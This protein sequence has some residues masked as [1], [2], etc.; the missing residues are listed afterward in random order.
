MK[1]RSM[2]QKFTVRVPDGF[3]RVLVFRDRR[4]M[5]KFADEGVPMWAGFMEKRLRAGD[6]FYARCMSWGNRKGYLGM[7]LFARPYLGVGIV[8]HEISHAAL[9]VAQHRKWNLRKP[10]NDERLAGLNE[11]MNRQFWNRFYALGEHKISA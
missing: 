3:Y 10:V 8:S 7:L 6:K 11:T 4:T 9:H 5:L 2:F 1:L